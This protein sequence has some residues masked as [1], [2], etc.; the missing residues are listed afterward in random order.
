MTDVNSTNDL[1]ISP[2]EDLQ[3]E[4]CLKVLTQAYVTN[5]INIAVLGSGD[6]GL[7][8]GK[9]IFGLMLGMFLPDETFVATSDGQ[10]LG[11]VRFSRYPNC[12]PS[13]RQMIS[14][15]PK[16]LFS[17]G[18]STTRRVSKWLSAWEEVHP[19]EAHYH[20]GPI[21]VLP[22]LQGKGIGTKLMEY[23]CAAMDRDGEAGYLET[24]RPENVTFYSK[25]GFQV[26][27]ELPVLGVPNWFMERPKTETAEATDG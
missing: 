19:H 9:K 7:R 16:M 17:L 13:G 3:K 8:R 6:V 25:F 22:E 24:D 2:L 18:L 26:I 27:Q 15:V 11:V 20:L 23:Y 21:A 1:L 14:L 5:P 12:L 10:V 4:E